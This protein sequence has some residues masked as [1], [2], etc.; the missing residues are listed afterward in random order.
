MYLYQGPPK[1]FKAIINKD[2]PTTATNSNFVNV[3]SSKSSNPTL[4]RGAE[5]FI[6][7]RVSGPV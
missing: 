5:L 2:K 4:E 7:D 6:T 3:F 1:P